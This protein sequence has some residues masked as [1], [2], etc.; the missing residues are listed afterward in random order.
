LGLV[1]V[2]VVNAV[3][4]IHMKIINGF[5]LFSETG[6]VIKWDGVLYEQVV[7]IAINHLCC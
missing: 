4:M 1:K 2:G 5:R 3:M 7:N 6:H